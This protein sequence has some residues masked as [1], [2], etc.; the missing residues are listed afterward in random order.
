MREGSGEQKVALW[1]G[2]A[3]AVAGGLV[4][5]GYAVFYFSRAFFGSPDVPLPVQ[6]AVP[7]VVGGILILIVTALAERLRRRKKESLEEIDY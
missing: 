5:V 3:L 2:G 7:A 4:L 1:I 6:V